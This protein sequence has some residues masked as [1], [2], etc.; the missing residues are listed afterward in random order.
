MHRLRETHE[1]EVLLLRFAGGGGPDAIDDRLGL[2]EGVGVGPAV[3]HRKAVVQQHD[4]VRLHAA[5]AGCPTDCATAAGPPSAPRAAMAAIRSSSSSSCLRMIQVRCFR[6]LT[7]RNS[8]AAHWTRRWRI[9]LI[10]WINTG[11]GHDRQSPEQQRMNKG[12]HEIR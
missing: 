3:G 8:M 10:R 2:I 5:E 12:W 11:S 1:G 6:W 7:R 4:V 9:M